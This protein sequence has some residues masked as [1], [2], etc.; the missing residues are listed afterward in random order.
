MILFG[1]IVPWK[2]LPGYHAFM[3]LF[4]IFLSLVWVCLCGCTS[5]NKDARRPNVLFI[6]IDDLRPELG[7]YGAS[8]VISPNIDRLAES[9]VVF[10]RAYCQSAVCNPSRASLMTGKYP[11]TI[12][13]LDLGTDLRKVQP[14]V[15]TLP[16]HL[17][18]DGYFTASIGKIYHNIFPDEASWDLR[19]YIPGFPFDPD[20]VYLSQKGQAIQKDR[21]EQWTK[22]GRAEQ[23]KD[24]FG[25]YYVK[26][27]AT[28]APDVADS[29]YYDGAQTDWAVDQLAKLALQQE[30]FFLAV[31]YYRPHLPFNAP[32]RY[33]DLYDRAQ[34]PLATGPAAAPVQNAPGMA[35]N[36]M[37]ELRGYSDYSNLAHPSASALSVDDQRLLIHGYLASVSYVDAQVGRLLEQLDQL[38]LAQNTIVVLWGD[39][40]WKLGE[41]QS[42]GKMT[43][44]EIDVRVPLLVRAPG[45]QLAGRRVT[46]SVELVDLFPTLCD[47]TGAPIPADLEGSS[48]APL[49]KQ[50][51]P[52]TDAAFSM[53]LREGI[54]VGPDGQEHIGRS[55]RTNSHRL[56]EW[57]S[58]A[59]QELTGLELYDHKTD[60]AES[61]NVAEVPQNAILV[62]ALRERLH[63]RE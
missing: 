47:L 40:G 48:L 54:W 6:A 15:V 41:H 50:D 61:R 35:I 46:A 10:E 59:S 12:G 20:A 18:T 44:Y 28:E 56:V 29:A 38:G 57:R 21:I 51:V 43:N 62:E 58:R 34:I 55:I 11:E 45:A 19:Q 7:C 17:R 33:W 39:H 2:F 22:R 25:H 14:D 32:S 49:L 16:Q 4:G 23:R 60:P 63:T 5:A 36:N 27:Q 9:G 37:R 8:H 31:G 24:R 30:P 42:W 3:K 26:A 53:Y 1:R 52:W 13:V